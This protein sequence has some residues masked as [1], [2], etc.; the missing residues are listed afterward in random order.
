M[1]KGITY[2]FGYDL[3]KRNLAKL[4]KEAG[5]DCIITSPDKRFNKENGNIAFQAKLA[6][7]SGLKLSSL[8]SRYKSSDLH[9]FWEE[10][11]KGEKIKQDLIEDVISAKKFGFK[12]VVVHLFGKYSKIGEQRLREVLD[13]CEKLNVPLAIENI[14]DKDTFVKTF[15][16]IKHDKLRFCYD[17]GHGNIFDRDFDYLEKYQDK[18]ICLHLHDNDSLI[19]YHTIS[20][21][22]EGLDWS[23]F[24]HS[25]QKQPSIIGGIGG[26][27]WNRVAKLVNEKQK[28]SCNVNWDKIAKI[29]AKHPDVSLDYEIMNR[30]DGVPKDPREFLKEAYEQATKLEKLIDSYRSA[31]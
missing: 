20:K 6:K 23:R 30:L 26:I 29:L 28:S 8:H 7:S 18:L 22:C 5:F 11:K 3:G 24:V 2:F 21:Y 13:V 19:D 1:D 14:N 16:N 27:D 9:Y 31:K 4:I 10:G 12:C 25:T 17:A 15:E